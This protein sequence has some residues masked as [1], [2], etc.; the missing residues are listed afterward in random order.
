MNNK[1]S[2]VLLAIIILAIVTG[3][4]YSYQRKPMTDDGNSR[5]VSLSASSLTIEDVKKV[6]SDEIARQL[7]GT[8]KTIR[9]SG[10]NDFSTIADVSDTDALQFQGLSGRTSLEEGASMLFIF[11][12]DGQ[13]RFWMKDMQFSIDMIWL[14]ATKKIISIE[15]DVSPESYPESFGPLTSTTRYVLEVPTGTAKKFD[16]KV[17]DMLNW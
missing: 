9:I 6:S 8:Y 13:Y 16:L 12:K 15:S 3:T 1:T 14:D 4:Y 5:A 11:P 2:T 10:K 7:A 17:G